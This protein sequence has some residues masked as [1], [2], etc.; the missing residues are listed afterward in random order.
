MAEWYIECGGKY[1]INNQMVFG[2]KIFINPKDIEETVAKRFNNVDAYTTNFLYNHEDQN[3][4][5]LIGPLYID[6]DG[7]IK[8]ESSYAKVKQDALTAISFI[9]T[10]LKV[11]KEYIRLYFSGSKGFHIIVPSIVFGIRPCKDLNNKYKMIALEISKHTINKTV[12]TRI[13]DKKRLIRLP[14]TING[15]TGLYKVPLSEE[16]LRAS[17]YASM[18][19]YARTDRSIEVETAKTIEHSRIAFEEMTKKKERPKKN[20]NTSF[21]NPNYEIPL[22]IKYIYANGAAEGGRNNTLVILASA[23]LQKG[24]ELEEC[25]DVMS[26][27]NES[28]NDPPL[29]TNE[30][31]ATVRSAYRNLVDGRRYGCASVAEIGMC[32]GKQCK[33]YNR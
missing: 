23:L 33:L 22:C 30:V 24:M 12:D 26:E 11:P 9:K 10:H 27:W 6:L 25:V 2:R 15:K 3:Q 31:E 32:V 16:I 1:N 18:K 14:H 20:G 5:D 19:L 4:S 28:K 21:I 7:D 13:Y 29:S 17:S 8:D